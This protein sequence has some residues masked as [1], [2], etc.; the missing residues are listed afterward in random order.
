M[1]DWAPYITGHADSWERTDGQY[2]LWVSQDKGYPCFWAV[3]YTD[4]RPADEGGGLRTVAEGECDSVGYAKGAAEK[5]L[6]RYKQARK[7]GVAR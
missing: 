2:H 7:W 5:A 4:P 1:S 6:R 3:R